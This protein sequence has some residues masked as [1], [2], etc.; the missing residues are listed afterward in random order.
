MLPTF[1]ARLADPSIKTVLL[2][3][4]GGGFDFL[5]GATLLPEL[6]RLGKRVILGS[7]SFGQPERIDDA[8]VVYTAETGAVVKQ[9]LA[10]SS[11]PP[12][13]GPEVHLASFLDQERPKS[14]PHFVYAYYARSFT[15][16]ALRAFY[17]ELVQRHEVDAVILVDG[18]SDSLMRGDEEGLGDPIED[19]VSVGAVASLEGVKLKL[20]CSIGLGAD[21][22]NGVSDAASLRAIAELTEAGGFLGAVS[23]EP[24]SP[25]FDFYK[26]CIE[27]VY[28]NQTFRSALTGFILSAAEGHFGG[29]SVPPAL[30]NRVSPGRFFVWPLMAMI[31]AFDVEVV[32]RRS[33]IVGWIHDCTTVRDCHL[34][35]GR[36]RAS[37][38][39]GPREVENLPRQEDMVGY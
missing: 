13:Y 1:L 6:E 20:L 32:A 21:R 22:F 30:R 12:D 14:A 34:A 35:L 28:A 17:A 26:R 36:G 7:Y 19:A 37:L 18:G 29:E 33:K 31:W 15:V 27:H 3:G 25:G 8:A 11:P 4:C 39:E 23:L 2:C 16:P 5:Q 9:V 24:T 38:A 10:Y